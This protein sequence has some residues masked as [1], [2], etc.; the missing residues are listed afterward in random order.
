MGHPVSNP[1]SLRLT[2]TRR[3]TMVVVPT[4]VVGPALMIGSQWSHFHTTWIFV[5]AAVTLASYRTLLITAQGFTEAWPD[6]LYN[7]LVGRRAQVAWE[8]VDKLE[9][10]PTLFGRCVQI[11]TRDGSRITLAAPRIDLT[12]RTSTFDETLHDLCVYPGGHRPSLLV[13]HRHWYRILLQSV[14]LAGLAVLLVVL[15]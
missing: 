11:V 8:D 3:P 7:H 14:L 2:P 5:G 15:R 6:G 10:V 1:A 4:A 13:E 12:S 9:V